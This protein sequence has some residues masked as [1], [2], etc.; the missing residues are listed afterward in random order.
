MPKKT[1]R[2]RWVS[3]S[4]GAAVNPGV[5]WTMPSLISSRQMAGQPI[6]AASRC[7]SVVLPEPGGPLTI[8]R[9]GSIG[10]LCQAARNPRRGQEPARWGGVGADAGLFAGAGQGKLRGTVVAGGGGGAGGG[11]GGGG[12][13]G[14]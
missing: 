2:V 4:P 7:A 1:G 8:T 3:S 11:A 10:T 12:G 6:A 14:R 13:G 9:V 5:A